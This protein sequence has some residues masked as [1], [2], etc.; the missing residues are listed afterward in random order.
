MDFAIFRRDYSKQKEHNIAFFS[1]L[2]IDA[3]DCDTKAL[4]KDLNKAADNN[5]RFLINGDIADAII[6]NDRK[7]YNNRD[8]LI[9]RNDHLNVI[10]E[11]V[12]EVLKPY[13]DYI[14]VIRCGNH[15]DAIVKH[16]NYDIIRGVITLL[17]RD[18]SDKLPAI[19]QG[20][21]R[22]FVTYLYHHGSNNAIRR[23][24]VYQHHG[25]GGSAPVSKGMIDFNRMIYSNDAD[26]YHTG[27]KHNSLVDSG[28]T[29][30][31]VDRSGRPVIDR[32]LAIQTAGYKKAYTDKDK[33]YSLAYSDRFYSYQAQGMIM[34][35]QDVSTT[36]E[37][38]IVQT[39]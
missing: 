15:E 23:T 34:V 6:P 38:S 1:D 5:C 22:G 24:V 19:H 35:K 26:I 2:H 18:R 3:A 37:R 36:I 28:V 39:I 7:R 21:Y 16:H 17:Q 13:A 12:Y 32:K 4:N 14:D 29:R 9:D 10:T 30:V 11:H 31:R 20:D 27:H 8:D 33:G 25:A